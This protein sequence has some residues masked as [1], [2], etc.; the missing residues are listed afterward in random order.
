MNDDTIPSN[1]QLTLVD[2]FFELDDFGDTPPELSIDQDDNHTIYLT[3]NIPQ[4]STT[5]QPRDILQSINAIFDIGNT[6]FFGENGWQQ[7]DPSQLINVVKSVYKVVDKVVDGV[8]IIYKLALLEDVCELVADDEGKIHFT[9]NESTPFKFEL[10]SKI[11]SLGSGAKFEGNYGMEKFSMLCKNNGMA[12]FYFKGTLELNVGIKPVDITNIT[13]DEGSYILPFKS[14]FGAS[15]GGKIGVGLHPIV[16][17][18]LVVQQGLS[19][20]FPITFEKTYTLTLHNQYGGWLENKLEDM[21]DGFNVYGFDITEDKEQLARSIS[22]AFEP[23]ARLAFGLSL[24][25]GGKVEE[26]TV[27]ITLG[28]SAKVTAAQEGDLD[29]CVKFNSELQGKFGVDHKNPIYSVGMTF[30]K[31]LFGNDLGQIC[32]E[33]NCDGNITSPVTGRVWMACN[34]GASRVCQSLNDAQCY[35]DYYQWGRGNT[36]FTPVN[37][38]PWDWN[39]GDSSGATRQAFWSKTDGSGICPKGFRVPTPA[40]LEAEQIADRA[41][42]FSKLKL[43]ASGNRYYYDG[44]LYGQGSNGTLWSSSPQAS[45]AWHLYWGSDYAYTG[46]H[47]RANGFPVRCLRD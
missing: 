31:K 23:E 42:A 26:T 14:S 5:A 46:Y 27:G 29:S 34:L 1:D 18:K 41:D 8:K 19:K 22:I 25:A 13:V 11:G 36:S 10:A 16:G 43:P 38:S 15:V 45:G 40:E 12:G 3:F 2:T 47:H 7:I 28:A 20:E 17:Y 24:Q 37:E 32:F 4:M 44:D 9:E 30:D 6:I 39:P 35:G 21:G 33:L